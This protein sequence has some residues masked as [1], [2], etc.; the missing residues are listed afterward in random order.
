MQK[1]FTIELLSIPHYF[2]YASIRSLSL[3]TAFWYVFSIS[4]VLSLLLTY[5]L[6]FSVFGGNWGSAISGLVT[7]PIQTS[8]VVIILQPMGICNVA[9][10]MGWIVIHQVFKRMVGGSRVYN[11]HHISSPYKKTFANRL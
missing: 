4:V 3:G 9:G 2:Y 11:K 5:P 10:E 7:F 6:S 1:S 8:G